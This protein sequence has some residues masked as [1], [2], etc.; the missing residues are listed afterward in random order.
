MRVVDLGNVLEVGFESSFELEIFFFIGFPFV[1][2]RRASADDATD[3]FSGLLVQFWPGV[4]DEENHRSDQA[5]CLPAIT[6][7]LLVLAGER[8]RIVEN[9]LRGFEAQTVVALVGAVLGFGPSPEHFA[10]LIL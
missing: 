9:Q 1:C 6:V 10:A 8:Q 5:H 2:R 7:R 3:F 4:D